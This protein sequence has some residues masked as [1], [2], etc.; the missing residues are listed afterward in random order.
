MV[1]HSSGNRPMTGDHPLVSVVMPAFGV[2]AYIPQALDSVAAQTYPNWEVVVVDD[3]GPDDGMAVSVHRFAAQHPAHRVELIRHDANMGVSAA[4][5]TAI[6]ASRGEL[7]AFLDPDD[8]W[9]SEHL[10]QA[11][12]QFIK[13]PGIEVSSGPVEVFKAGPEGDNARVAG[14]EAWRAR[15][16]P[17][18]LALHNFIQPSATVVRKDALDRVG[19]FDTD[20]GLQHIEDYDLWIRLIESGSRFAFLKRPTSRYRKHEGGATSDLDRM[21]ELHENLFRKHV[22]FFRRS[23]VSL[24]QQLLAHQVRFEQELT[25]LK[26]LSNGPSF[27]VL[28]AFD[29]AARAAWRFVKGVPGPDRSREKHMN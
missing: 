13:R 11:R 20:P 25:A 5:N 22:A 7:V 3:H 19:G 2:G 8:L 1:Q 10:E 4:R 24:D 26:I 29:R 16:F 18:T 17:A 14:H 28:R 21:H 12:Q 23:A 9:L 27:R 6:A 15:F